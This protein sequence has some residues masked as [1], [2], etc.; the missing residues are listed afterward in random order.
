[1]GQFRVY[2]DVEESPEPTVDVRA[3]GVKERNEVRIGGRL[4]D[5]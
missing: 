2:Y 5:L 4:V 3:V 1:M